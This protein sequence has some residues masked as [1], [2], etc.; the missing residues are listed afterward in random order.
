[1]TSVGA[2]T[3]LNLLPPSVPE[4]RETVQQDYQR[5]LAGLDIVQPHVA[6][7]GV[8]LTNVATQTQHHRPPRATD[9]P[10]VPPMPASSL[11][12]PA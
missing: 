10:Q 7:L 9:S 1:M 6:D 5:P 4:L 11:L 12:E 8:A 3:R 2:S